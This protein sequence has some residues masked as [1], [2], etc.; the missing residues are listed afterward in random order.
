M[1]G[2]NRATALPAH[3]PEEFKA[4]HVAVLDRDR[5]KCQVCFTNTQ[6]SAHH[7]KPRE[8]GGSDEPRNGITLCR[9]CHDRAELWPW[10]SFWSLM[11][12]ARMEHTRQSTDG[13]YLIWGRDKHGVFSVEVDPSPYRVKGKR[14]VIKLRED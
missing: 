13:R 8:K 12:E 3:W 5:H 7:I 9:S 14:K 2:I 10:E 6:L 4:F 11:H 1:A